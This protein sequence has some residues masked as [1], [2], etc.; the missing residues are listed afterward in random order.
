MNLA[1]SLH[2]QPT[3]DKGA[4]ALIISSVA[5]SLDTYCKTQLDM[6]LSN[7]MCYG[8][9]GLWVTVKVQ[10][11]CL[12]SL[13][14]D[15]LAISANKKAD[16]HM[17]TWT[18]THGYANKQK[19]P[20]TNTRLLTRS[21]A[22]AGFSNEL[23]NPSE[24]VNQNLILEKNNA[25]KT[26]KNTSGTL[27]CSHRTSWYCGDDKLKHDSLLQCQIIPNTMTKLVKYIIKSLFFLSVCKYIAR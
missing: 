19:V 6:W 26:L 2:L 9:G 16:T 15:F 12:L 14:A 11:S 8:D 1:I 27:L 10:T 23:H 18:Q 21:D 3:S 7:Y 25:N 24:A 4:T 22:Y 5:K 17:H 13:T 20:F